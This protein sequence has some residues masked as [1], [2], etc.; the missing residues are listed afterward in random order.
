MEEATEVEIVDGI[1]LLLA[2]NDVRKEEGKE[3]GEKDG[4]KEGEWENA[5]NANGEAEETAAE[6]AIVE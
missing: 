3:D 6:A 4:N 2:V 5:E 1:M